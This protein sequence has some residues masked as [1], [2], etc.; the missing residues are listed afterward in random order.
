MP[1]DLLHAARILGAIEQE[2]FA[3][4]HD[5]GRIEGGVRLPC[6]RGIRRDDRVYAWRLGE[7]TN[8]PRLL[9]RRERPAQD[10]EQRA[11]TDDGSQE[12]GGRREISPVSGT[13]MSISNHAA[14]GTA[15]NTAA[16]FEAGGLS[17]PRANSTRDPTATS[18]M[19]PSRAARV[20]AAQRPAYLLANA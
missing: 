14:I 16:G 10:D 12:T 9:V 19:T 11:A 3:V 13:A 2:D 1:A 18:T 6:H 15:T 4:L 17:A 5:G 20:D 8:H 7:R